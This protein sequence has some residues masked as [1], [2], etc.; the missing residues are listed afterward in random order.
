[1]TKELL[2]I[3]TVVGVHG[4]NGYLKVR[5][6]GDDWSK[7]WKKVFISH[8]DEKKAFLIEEAKF[9]GGLILLK[10]Q[11][12]STRDDG[13]R[14]K[15]SEVFLDKKDLPGLSEGE[16]YWFELEGFEVYSEGGDFLGTIE[17]V[18]S[19]GSN[20]VFVIKHGNK[21]YLI[22]WIKSVVISIS[23]RAKKMII[24]PIEGLI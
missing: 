12:I 10:L 24:C 7:D 1:M 17:E 19:T 4:I 14:L 21:E 2:L 16:F 23:K 5:F 13:L 20:D 6:Q 9:H 3:G 18:F 22:P 8:K 15:G 11:D